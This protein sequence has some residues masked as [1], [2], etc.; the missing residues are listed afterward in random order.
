MTIPKFDPKEM[1]V[2]NTVPASVFSPEMKIYSYPV[3][4][5]EAFL[6]MMKRKPIWQMTGLDNRIFTPRILPDNVSR[7]FVFEGQK[8]YQ[9]IS[10]LVWPG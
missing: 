5:R 1:E 4:V 9:A 8:H 7:A 3:P 2:V 10:R 6:S